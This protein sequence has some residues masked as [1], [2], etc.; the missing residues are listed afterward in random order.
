MKIGAFAEK[1]KVS[2]DTVRFYVKKG[3]LTP[4]SQGSQMDFTEQDCKDMGS[5]LQM[6][7]MQ[8]SLSE[9]QDFLYLRRMSNF[10]EPATL[11]RCIGILQN[12]Q[13]ELEQEKQKLEQG[14]T[15]LQN[16]IEDLQKRL[17]RQGRKNRSGVPLAAFTLLQCPQCGASLNLSQAEIE[18]RYIMNGKISC[19]CGYRAAVQDGI[20]L[21]ENRYTGNHDTPDMERKLYH[22]NLPEYNAC[23]LKCPEFML[24]QLQKENMTGKVALEANI[25]G[26]FFTY[27][28]LSQLPHDCTYIIVDKYPEVVAMYKSLIESLYDDLDILYIADAGEHYPLR[29]GSVDYYL[30]LFGENEYSYYH[31]QCQI[32]DIA[33]LLR[34]DAKVIGAFQSVKW[35]SRTRCNLQ[36]K[37]PEG[38][39]RMCSLPALKKEYEENGFYLQTRLLGTVLKTL[40]HHM[41]TEHVDG[42]TIEMY[43][44]T[45]QRKP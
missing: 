14:M 5:I 26:F 16:G 9:I 18:G 25:N 45:A 37:Y 8:L 40:K 31:K 6:K 27:N 28:F 24:Q 34:P 3:L 39:P 33:A 41:Y 11:H 19:G 29:K 7:A 36:R 2:R 35:N 23:A 1:Y 38:S 4:R 22:E 15:L 43:G 20:V 44:Y 10:I 13:Q 12:K 17:S 32:H 30:A 21:T 42:E